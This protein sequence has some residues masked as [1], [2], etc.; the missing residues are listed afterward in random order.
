MQCT[1][2]GLGLSVCLYEVPAS[3]VRLTTF[4]ALRFSLF[5]LCDIC[6]SISVSQPVSAVRSD[7]GAILGI[8]VRVGI[9]PLS[10]TLR[11]VLLTTF[12]SSEFRSLF[13]E[14][15]LLYFEK[16]NFARFIAL[17]GFEVMK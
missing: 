13:K 6:L 14:L 7:V 17:D 11:H 9:I 4:A 10:V 8:V 16:K 5:Y 3:F 1:T 2:P 12:L 15:Y